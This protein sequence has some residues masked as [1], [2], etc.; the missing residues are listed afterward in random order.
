ML[1][2]TAQP[3][4]IEAGGGDTYHAGDSVIG[5]TTEFWTK[6]F[7]GLVE[8]ISTGVTKGLAAGLGIPE[9]LVWIGGVALI[10]FL[11]KRK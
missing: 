3:I 7:G 5:T 11:L 9:P 4:P 1:R 2:D 8:N 10:V 6:A